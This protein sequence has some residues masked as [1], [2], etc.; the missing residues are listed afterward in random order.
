MDG[1]HEL[2]SRPVEATKEEI[3]QLRE[4]DGIDHIDKLDVPAQAKAE[5]PDSANA[6][7]HESYIIFPDEGISREKADA[8][9]ATLREVLQSRIRK[10][11]IVWKEKVGWWVAEM[12]S[13]EVGWVSRVDGV[14]AVEQNVLFEGKFVSI[15]KY[16]EPDAGPL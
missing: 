4:H 2:S 11:S 14:H 6:G 7:E 9:D 10:P 12:N 13:T 5:E 16:S 8:V 3:S 1:H 15:E